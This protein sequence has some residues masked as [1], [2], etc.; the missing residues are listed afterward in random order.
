MLQECIEI[1]QETSDMDKLILD[2][3]VPSD[4]TYIIME[5]REDGFIQ[6]EILEIKLDKKS[7][8]LN[9]TEEEKQ[10]ISYMDYYCRL[11]DMNKPID[12]KK[13]IH[14]NNYLS[15]WIKKENINNGKLTGEIIDTYYELLANPYKKYKDV[16]DKELYC[17]VERE[18][19]EVNKEKVQKIKKWIKD[20]IF[21]L[22]IEQ[23]GKD[24]L[25]IFFICNGTDFEKEARR[26]ILPNIFN[27]NDY[28]VKIGEK[29]LGLPNENMGL[30]SKK[31]YLDNKNRKITVPVLT[32]TKQIMIRKKFF[33]YLWN[34]TSK[35]YSNIYF[36]ME[37]KRILEYDYKT[38]P[39]SVFK[40]FFLRIRKDKNEAAIVDMDVITSY[41]P[42]LMKP[43][44]IENVIGFHE[45]K[46]TDHTYGRITKLSELREL[47]NK[48][49]FSKLLLTNFYTEP[50]EIDIDDSALEE[51]ILLARTPLFNW[52]YKGY[53]SGIV[54]VIDKI[55]LKLIKNTISKNYLEKA[56]HQFNIRISLIEYFKGG[57]NKMADVIKEIRA[58][59]RDKINSQK[60]TSINS[61]E[62]Y[63]YAVGQIIGFFISLNKSSKKNHSLFNPFLNIKSDKMLKEKLV[64]L[65]KKYN[66]AI[67]EKR[68]LRFNNLYRLIVSYI[69]EKEI[70]QDYMIAGYISSNLI[71]EK[72]ED[73]KV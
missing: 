44:F 45:D 49:L 39:G 12:P 65:F 38:S 73:K 18:I 64:Q 61:D 57:R 11:L 3:Y 63:Y 56:G 25:K 20:N 6:K 26:Y 55:S 68:W 4:G 70:N 46:L 43:I 72:K 1:F 37:K 16:K 52:F 53:D 60:Y 29:I 7:K 14:S 54:N 35:G 9:I 48:E 30:N 66:Y 50:Q 51:C 5:E 15:F 28:N 8:E 32:D 62:E 59:L 27:K 10:R 42:E 41:R 40:G 36:D 24:Y 17:A 47:L 71:Y 21:S 19:G 33:D 34:L 2:T 31:P 67:E 58:T 13:V 69:P 22:P 23:N